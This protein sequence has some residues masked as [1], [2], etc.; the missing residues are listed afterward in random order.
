MVDVPSAVIDSVQKLGLN[1]ST[2]KAN[3]ELGD[4]VVKNIC[5]VGAGYV[6]EYNMMQDSAFGKPSS[7]RSYLEVI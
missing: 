5:C 4:V 2:S 6:G 7:P 3:G 1:G